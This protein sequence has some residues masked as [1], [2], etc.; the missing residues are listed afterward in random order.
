MRRIR[1]RY[2]D[3]EVEAVLLDDLAPVTTAALWAH[4]PFRDRAVSSRWSGDC[5]RTELDHRLTD[6][7]T[8]MENPAEML[9]AGDVYYIADHGARKYR[10]GFAWA[11]S[12]PMQPL[13]VPRVPTVVAKVVAGLPAL[14]ARSERLVYE[15]PR[16]IELSR[17]GP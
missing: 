2:D 6:P 11:A 8:A 4:L 9:G 16:P 3:V 17:I 13:W 12:R 10:L 14:V 5:W 7:G 1:I 15:G